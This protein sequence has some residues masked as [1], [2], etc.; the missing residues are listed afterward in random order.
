MVLDGDRVL[1]IRR[2]REPLKG[3]WSIP[4]GALELG[5]T[6]EAGVRREIAEET[7]LEVRVLGMVEVLDRIALEATTEGPATSGINPR[8]Q[9]HY[10]LIDFLCVPVGGHLAF[11][12][13][14]AEARWVAREDLAGYGLAPV[15]AGV[16]EK[17]FE[18]H[19]ASKE[20]SESA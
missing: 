7:G 3:E 6:L 19:R 15:T 1:L 13:D 20:K 5:E 10:V 11:G 9:Y 4:G 2:D 17:A 8:V 12:S 16:I 18:I 14:A